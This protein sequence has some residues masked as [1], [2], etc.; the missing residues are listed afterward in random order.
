MKL[1]ASRRV[2]EAVK[3]EML[4]DAGQ[5]GC[6]RERSLAWSLGCEEFVDAC[7]TRKAGVRN[8][9]G[10]QRARRTHQQR[11]AHDVRREIRREAGKRAPARVSGASGSGRQRVRETREASVE[12][13]CVWGVDVG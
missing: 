6:E 3:V 13:G 4:R 12:G 7:A 1:G 11:R 2:I 8:Q 5:A 10:R 9:D